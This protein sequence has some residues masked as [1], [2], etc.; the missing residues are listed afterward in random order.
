MDG[1]GGPSVDATEKMLVESSDQTNEQEVVTFSDNEPI[2]QSDRGGLSVLKS[3]PNEPSD[4]QTLSKWLARPVLLG[5]YLWADIDSNLTADM[6]VPLRDWLSRSSVLAKYTNYQFL[7][8]NLHLRFQINAS[9]FHYGMKIISF[10]PFANQSCTG[11]TGAYPVLT[12]K[13]HV[14][15]TA[16]QNVTQDFIIP[17]LNPRNFYNLAPQAYTGTLEQAMGI[18]IG[19]LYIQDINPLRQANVATPDTDVYITVFAW[20]DDARLELPTPLT[21]ALTPVP[22]AGPP[23][24]KKES[25]EYGKGP[26]STTATA[27]ASIAS[28]LQDVPILGPFAR[29]TQIGASAVGAIA[30]IFGFSRPAIIS[31]PSFMRPRGVGFLSYTE[32]GDNTE[33][34]TLDPKNEVF[35]DP[36]VT[37]IGGNKDDMHLDTILKRESM[38]LK[39]PWVSTD[40]AGTILTRFPVSPSLSPQG[41]A[42]EFTLFPTS[43]A[44]GVLPFK[45]WTGSIVYRIQVIA[46]RYHRGRIRVSYIPTQTN[47]VPAVDL[48][49]TTWN[50]IIDIESNT[51]VTLKIEYN[52][53]TPWSPVGLRLFNMGTGNGPYTV[54]SNDSQTNVEGMLIFE[55]LND[56]V[57]PFAPTT[58]EVNVFVRAGDDFK[59]AFPN[60]KALKNYRLGGNVQTVPAL[61][62]NPVTTTRFANYQYQ[63]MGVEHTCDAATTIATSN[64][65]EFVHGFGDNGALPGTH[66]GESIGSLRALFKRYNVYWSYL[67][68]TGDLSLL[69][70]IHNLT[71]NPVDL[72]SW[73]SVWFVGNQVTA[74][75]PWHF[76]TYFSPTYVARRGGVRYKVVPDARCQRN[77]VAQGINDIFPTAADDDLWTDVSAQT[78]APTTVNSCVEVE[79]PYYMGMNYMVPSNFYQNLHWDNFSPDLTGFGLY[80]ARVMEQYGSAI[81]PRSTIYLAAAEDYTLHWYIGSLPLLLD[82]NMNRASIDVGVNIPE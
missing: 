48:S 18:D 55:V 8:G 35:I 74:A 12:S 33:K 75:L 6:I 30:S 29:A 59:V 72:P 52:N 41:P 82:S 53:A 68:E 19:R 20:M 79:I 25:D 24:Q 63:M 3:L 2:L 43:L 58:C 70:H 61:G 51:E 9:P 11:F 40:S 66:F 10:W 34:L 42:P 64:A 1:Q 57:G 46:S 28:G 7:R 49:N 65:D 39:F 47:A 17:F 38:L 26:I 14:Y 16:G 54:N 23:V 69:Q 77:I 60:F 5:R 50:R 4:S 31:D 15:L 73:Y 27:V 22:Q 71:P 45:W 44:Y 13:P 80:G 62:T 21:P 56:L 78:I 67:G 36:S 37:G 81:I 76:L 32:G